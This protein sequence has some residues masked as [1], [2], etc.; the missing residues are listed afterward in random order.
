M[1]MRSHERPTGPQPTDGN[2]GLE[3]R[4]SNRSERTKRDTTNTKSAKRERRLP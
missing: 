2:R 3:V 1:G 4:G